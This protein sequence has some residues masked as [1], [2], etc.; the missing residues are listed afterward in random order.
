MS[1]VAPTSQ[2]S[3]DYTVKLQKFGWQRALEKEKIIVLAVFITPVRPFLDFWKSSVAWA[4]AGWH[5]THYNNM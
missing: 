2:R 1:V 3:R 4:A 5:L